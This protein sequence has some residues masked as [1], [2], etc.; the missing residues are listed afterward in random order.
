MAEALN[1]ATS[2]IGL[3]TSLST[4][5]EWFTYIQDAR[6]FNSDV[7]TELLTLELLKS[8]LSRWGQAVGIDNTNNKDN[9]DPYFSHIQATEADI[10][11]ARFTI[12][13]IL[14]LIIKSEKVSSKYRLAVRSE[15]RLAKIIHSVTFT[16]MEKMSTKM[17]AKAEQRQKRPH[18]VKR[19]IWAVYHKA[20]YS[21]LVSDVTKLVD[22]LEQ[23]FPAPKGEAADFE[24]SP[25]RGRSPPVAVDVV[26][27]EA[28]KPVTS[29]YDKRAPDFRRE[30]GILNTRLTGL[31]GD[32]II[33]S[34]SEMVL[35]T[36]YT[37]EQEY[38]PE[39]SATNLDPVEDFTTDYQEERGS[40]EKIDGIKIQ[41]M[42]INEEGRVK[43]GNFV[44]TAWKGEEKLPASSGEVWQ[45]KQ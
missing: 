5:V 18:V 4:C 41:L 29:T 3:A 19:S 2:A 11:L 23:A 34:G 38:I 45:S 7:Q 22:N 33:P 24:R 21:S 9:R 13:Q 12:D 25:D 26:E 27:D 17:R 10:Q 32:T 28:V 44:S 6:R 37:E 43:N 31:S 30:P 35:A 42:N 36:R 1:L 15:D 14:E 16:E 20:R 8:R 39:Q 40:G